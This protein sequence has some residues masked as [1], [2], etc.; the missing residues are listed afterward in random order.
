MARKKKNGHKQSVFIPQR[1]YEWIEGQSQENG[2]D[3][4]AQINFL[5]SQ[6]KGL[7][8]EKERIWNEYLSKQAIKEGKERSEIAQAEKFEKNKTPTLKE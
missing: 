3:V 6:A 4:T 7:I 8:E 1:L 2:I 5:L